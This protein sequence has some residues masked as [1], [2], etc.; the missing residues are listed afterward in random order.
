M[1]FADI[2]VG[3]VMYVPHVAEIDFGS[4]CIAFRRMFEVATTV[5]SVESNQFTA[6]SGI[7]SKLDGKSIDPDRPYWIYKKPM[8]E[9]STHKDLEEYQGK[10]ETIK[11]AHNV[12]FDLSKANGAEHALAV[13]EILLQARAILDNKY[14]KAD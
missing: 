12:G 4:G 10:L 2:K 11:K 1:E 8:Y 6:G 3:D 7:F 13:A 9:H 5:S 14:W